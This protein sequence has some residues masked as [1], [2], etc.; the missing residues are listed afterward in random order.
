MAAAE[1]I[2]AH[3]LYS[4]TLTDHLRS[5]YIRYLKIASLATGLK[6][7]GK[8]IAYFAAHPDYQIGGQGW[9]NALVVS[10]N[11][12]DNTSQ[13]LHEVLSALLDFARIKATLSLGDTRLL[14]V[15]QNP[16]ATLPDGESQLLALTGWSRESLNAL[17]TRF[18]KNPFDPG[19][20]DGFRGDLAHLDTFRRVYDASANVTAFGI[21]ASALLQATINEPSADTVRTFQLALHACYGEAAWLSVLKP[22]NDGL[23]GLQRD[24]LVA[25]TLQKL[26]EHPATSTIDTA[27]KLFEYFLMDVQMDPC[28]QTSRVRQALSS[29][30][31]FIERCL[32]NLEPKVAPSSIKANRWEWMKRYRTW[33]AN[34][35]VFLWPEN[36]LEPELRDDQSPFFKEAM[37]QLL[38]SDITEESAAVV[39]LDYLSKLEEVAKLEPCS[40][41]YAENNPGVDDDIAHVV[42]RTTGARRKYYY[43]RNEFG[44]W[45]PWEQIKL[46]IEDNPVLPVVWNGRL[47]LF[48][49]HI[50]KTTPI[51]SGSLQT[52]TPQGKMPLPSLTLDI[53]KTDIKASTLSDNAPV[54]VQAVL[55][56]SEYYN[57]KWQPTKTSDVNSPLDLGSFPLSDSHAFDRSSLQLFSIAEGEGKEEGEVLRVYI[58]SI[59]RS[60]VYSSFRLYNTHSLPV[61]MAD[62]NKSPTI[63]LS[64]LNRFRSVDPITL[65]FQY[66]NTKETSAPKVEITLLEEG[67]R[68][69]PFT[70]IEPGNQLKNSWVAPFFFQDSRHAFY[71][72][73][74]L[75]PVSLSH[76]TS[77]GLAVKWVKQPL[78][79]PSLEF[80]QVPTL[81]RVP[82]A[83]VPLSLEPPSGVGDPSP[84]ERSVSEGVTIRINTSATVQYD[85]SEI[86]PEGV[87]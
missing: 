82:G 11:P 62:E 35:K 18:G 39:L 20:L 85:G 56:L 8:E 45:T 19:H 7:T 50:L 80:R 55:C 57:G 59:N 53:I 25:Y 43:R 66:Q 83:F 22:I 75:P 41:Y 72:K 27:E 37:S 44:S 84:L 63:F 47:L 71:V 34:R 13:S 61:P 21:S 4:S 6:L 58:H 3:S 38:Q 86:G 23:R 76:V 5:T 15:L 26:K 48:W 31:L 1:V 46:D 12:D 65:A 70:L 17:L 28:M 64:N 74:I 60:D 2:P 54:Q 79:I 68:S 67:N 16:T 10:G 52:D 51:G 49:L 9:L 77:F 40:I 24:A 69:T 14:A 32:M 42:A 33:E 30:Q 78:K 29:V 36:W 87:L 81:T 73:T